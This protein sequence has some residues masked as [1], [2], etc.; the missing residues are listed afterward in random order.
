[1]KFINL[2]AAFA[3]ILFVGCGGGSETPQ[4]DQSAQA[5]ST[6]MSKDVRTIDIIGIDI[7]KFVVKD[8]SKGITV[9]KTA[10]KDSLLTL[11]GITVKP[12]QK[13]R[14]TLTTRSEMAATAMA[15]NWLLLTPNADAKA[16]A[17]AAMRA[18]DNDYVPADKKDQIIAQT[19]LAA[20]GQTTE[21]TFTAPEKT[22]EYDY[23]CTFPAH[24]SNGMKG[25][26]T[27]EK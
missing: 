25:I 26:L 7:M 11:K 16:F 1:M 23:I 17:Q 22:G 20:G 4:Q 3:L 21:V 18:R 6:Q 15:H 5:D 13:I 8:D 24:Y 2:L 9:G 10:G 14:I 12:G 19:G 27:V